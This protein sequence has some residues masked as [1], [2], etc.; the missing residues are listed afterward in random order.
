M[1]PGPT[2]YIQVNAVMYKVSVDVAESVGAWLREVVHFL[3]LVEGRLDQA[4]GF[5]LCFHCPIRVENE[6]PSII[7]VVDC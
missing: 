7:I 5:H 1:V 3:G 2:C 6:V 4:R